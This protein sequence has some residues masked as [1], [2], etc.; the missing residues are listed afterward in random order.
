MCVYRRFHGACVGRAGLLQSWHLLIVRHS[1][2]T[3][4]Q[5]NLVVLVSTADYSCVNFKL[6]RHRRYHFQMQTNSRVKKIFHF[7]CGICR[8]RFFS[9]DIVLDFNLR[10]VFIMCGKTYAFVAAAPLVICSIWK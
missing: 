7:S 1:N 10:S 6:Q 3:S 9:I 8:L 2:H 5:E 4:H